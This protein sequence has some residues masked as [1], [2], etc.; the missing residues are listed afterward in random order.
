MWH[1]DEPFNLEKIVPLPKD[2]DYERDARCTW[3]TKWGCYDCAFS[4]G[5]QDTVYYFRTAW[6]PF[7]DTVMKEF[8]VKFP[9]LNFRYEW[10]EWGGLDYGVKILNDNGLETKDFHLSEKEGNMIEKIMNEWDNKT[11]QHEMVK[12]CLNK[13]KWKHLTGYLELFP[14][15][16]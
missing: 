3:G 7:D 6:S 16:G 14:T 2:K 11:K 15:S 12:R 1:D 10:A 5:R 9:T 13:K 8:K 4:H